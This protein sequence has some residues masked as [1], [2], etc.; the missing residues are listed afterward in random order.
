MEK[1][2]V[3]YDLEGLDMEVLETVEAPASNGW[4]WGLGFGVGLGLIA[5][6]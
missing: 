1:D 2:L 3:N 6:T 5:L 4:E